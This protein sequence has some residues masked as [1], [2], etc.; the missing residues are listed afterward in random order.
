MPIM[1]ARPWTRRSITW[2]RAM[3]RLRQG[4]RG[5][6]S[7][8][9]WSQHVWSWTARPT[10]HPPDALRGH[11][12]DPERAF[13]AL[14]RHLLEADGPATRRCDRVVV[15]RAVKAQE[16]RRISRTAAAS[17]PGLFA[18]AAPASGRTCYPARSSSWC[19]TMASR[20][21]ASAICRRTSRP[22]LP[23]ESVRRTARNSNPGFARSAPRLKSG[24]RLERPASARYAW[25]QP[26]GEAGMRQIRIATSPSMR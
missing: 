14:A 13:G 2:R 16:R 5:V 19:G 3:P 10:R 21:G 4:A 18:K 12:W 22:R 11:A 7:A 6:R 20:C 26:T 9:L 23:P 15:V 17:R 8:R 25:S 1:P 24:L